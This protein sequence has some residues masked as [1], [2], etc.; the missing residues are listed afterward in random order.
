M[1]HCR[2]SWDAVTSVILCA[3]VDNML[4]PHMV[5]LMIKST[6]VV[7][8]G[9][10]HG[11]SGAVLL[12]WPCLVVATDTADRSSASKKAMCESAVDNTLGVVG[13]VSWLA[14]QRCVP[15]IGAGSSAPEQCHGT[16]ESCCGQ[17]FDGL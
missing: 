1:G 16:H 6:E 9:P 5:E 15:S 17:W 10:Q 8:R 4:S 13:E 7:P 12:A 11:S 3:F 2:H 14:A